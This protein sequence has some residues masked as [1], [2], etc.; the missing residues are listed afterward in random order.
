MASEVG[1]EIGI[2]I[3]DVPVEAPV[4]RARVVRA[5]PAGYGVE[6]IV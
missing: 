1:E 4:V 3:L 2:Q 5:D 6:F